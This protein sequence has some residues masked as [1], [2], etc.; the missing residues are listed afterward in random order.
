[1]DV[2]HRRAIVVY[3]V[4][5]IKKIRDDSCLL[6]CVTFRHKSSGQGFL[7]R[8]SRPPPDKEPAIRKLKL[9]VDELKV[10]SFEAS[11]GSPRI[12]TVRGQQDTFTNPFNDDPSYEYCAQT[13]GTCIGPTYCCPATWK[14]SCDT[15]AYTWCSNSECLGS[16][17]GSC[18]P[19]D[20]CTDNCQNCSV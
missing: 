18:A 5:V 2:T 4:Q 16:C 12:G 11:V 17:R 7:L 19:G 3:F 13:V 10:E 14:A 15:C 1:M 8:P 6:L 20:S 9:D